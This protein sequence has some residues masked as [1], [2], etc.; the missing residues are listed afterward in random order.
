MVVGIGDLLGPGWCGP[1]IVAAG[2]V[3][4]LDR[5]RVACHARRRG[6]GVAP[7]V[8]LARGLYALPG[9]PTLT[10][11]AAQLDCGEWELRP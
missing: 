1:S 10:V 9:V 11:T 2:A 5:S 6:G 7:R 8:T 3:P 4:S